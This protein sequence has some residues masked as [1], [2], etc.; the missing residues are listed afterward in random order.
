MTQTGMAREEARER[1]T[2]LGHGG[3]DGV[4]G[5][6]QGVTIHD[7]RE[8][9]GADRLAVVMGVDGDVGAGR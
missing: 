2:L 7:P 1:E 8:G 4:V 6:Q 9:H 5:E 3:G